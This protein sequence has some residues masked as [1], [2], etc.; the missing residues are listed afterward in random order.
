MAVKHQIEDKQDAMAIESIETTIKDLVDVEPRSFGNDQQIGDAAAWLQFTKQTEG[1]VEELLDPAIK[2]AHEAHKKLTTKKKTL[3]EKL[4]AAKDRV[5]VSVANWIAGGRDVSG[6]YIKRK[7]KVTVTKFEDLPDEYKKTVA[8]EEKLEQWANQTEGTV[9][10][11]GC[12]IDQVN[13]LYASGGEEKKASKPA[14]A[15]PVVKKPE[16]KPE[17]KMQAL[18]GANVI[19]VGWTDGLLRCMFAPSKEGQKPKYWIYFDVPAE[20]RDK[21]VRSPYPDK[22]F[23]QIVKGKFKGMA[24]DEKR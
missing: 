9:P 8:D 1:E 2:Q 4:L 5:R 11:A 15:A 7:W 3:M 18:K 20:V 21:L 19:G 6:Y 17:F 16:P 12:K 24:E 22:L 14:E 23:S 13:I 10:I